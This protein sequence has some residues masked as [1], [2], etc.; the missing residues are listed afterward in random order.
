MTTPTASEE[1]RDSERLSSSRDREAQNSL[2]R[3]IW[4]CILMCWKPV[5]RAGDSDADTARWGQLPRHQCAEGHLDVAKA[6]LEAGARELVML[7]MD[8]GVSC[9]ISAHLLDLEMGASC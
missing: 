5:A 2:V 9:L 4:M 1:L 6:L 8:D 3:W 7:T